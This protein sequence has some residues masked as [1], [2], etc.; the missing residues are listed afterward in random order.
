VDDLVG[1]PDALLGELLARL[2][3]DLHGAL[4]APAEAVGL[5]QLHGDGAPGVLV[6]VLL[7]RLDHITCETESGAPR[8]LI[9]AI[10]DGSG[11]RPLP[12]P[13]AAGSRSF[14]T[15]ST[16]WCTPGS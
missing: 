1:E 8:E 14:A 5:R 16:H 7:E 4:D 2:V 13:L 3:G 11:G 9:R 15:S 10:T 12:V 6:A